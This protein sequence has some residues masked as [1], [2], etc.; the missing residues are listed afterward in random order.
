LIHHW[1]WTRA[2][3]SGYSVIASDITAERKCGHTQVPIFMLAAVREHLRYCVSVGLCRLAAVVF[4]SFQRT[5]RR[6]R[7]SHLSIRLPDQILGVPKF[8][9]GSRRDRAQ[10]ACPSRGPL[11]PVSPGGPPRYPKCDTNRMT[12]IRSRTLQP[13]GIRTPRVM[14]RGIHPVIRGQVTGGSLAACRA[15]SAAIQRSA[16]LPAQRVVM[17][18]TGEARLGRT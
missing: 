2:E 5:C 8:V 1:Y 7:R 16:R 10:A 17:R 13:A 14:A 15:H 6:P 3:A 12:D 9:A 18:S 4:H 11:R